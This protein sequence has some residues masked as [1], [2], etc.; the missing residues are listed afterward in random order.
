M[1]RIKEKG[2][3]GRSQ[4]LQIETKTP[5]DASRASYTGRMQAGEAMK[6]K[7]RCSSSERRRI[8]PDGAGAR[9]CDSPPKAQKHRRLSSTHAH[10]VRGDDAG[11]ARP[12]LEALL[13]ILASAGAGS[14]QIDDWWRW[15][16]GSAGRV[17]PPH[18]RLA[19]EALLLAR[20]LWPYADDC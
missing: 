13:S 9:R 14:A 8:G 3:Q 7:E 19:Q 2:A 11:W 4:D 5:R 20:R 16:Q 15:W 10:T 17:Q 12:L 6:S 1:D 18:L